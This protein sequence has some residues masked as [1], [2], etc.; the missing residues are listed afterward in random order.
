MRPPSSADERDLVALAFLA[1]QVFDRDAAVVEVDLRGVAAVL[2]ELVFQPRHHVAGRAGGHDEGAHALLARAL[3][4]H[5]DDDGDIAVLAAGDE[6]LDAVDDVAVALL[7]GGRS[8]GRGVRAHMRLGQ[9][10]RAEHLALR[11]RREPLLLLRVVAVA[12]Q[13]GVDRA[14]GH[15]NRGAGAAVAGGDFFEHQR[16]RQVVELGAAVFLGHAD[17]VGA[18]LGQALVHVLGE[19]VFLVPFRGVRPELFL[20]KGAHRVADHFLVL[21]Q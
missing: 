11:Q 1:D 16:Q 6:L 9:A 19:V 12:H 7:H 21:G 10:E 17:A 3:V 20:G 8:Q 13:D 18:E 14:V 5:G 15:G 4:G 2:A